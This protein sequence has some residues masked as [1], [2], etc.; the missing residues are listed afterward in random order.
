MLFARI[1]PTPLTATQPGKLVVLSGPG[2]VGKSTV[3]KA[4]KNSSPFFVSISATTR[5]PRFNE[6]DGVDYHFL[7][8]VEIGMTPN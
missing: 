8:N 6:T 1:F 5:A 2:G 7:S 4:L 3:A